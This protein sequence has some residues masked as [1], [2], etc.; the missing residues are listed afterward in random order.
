MS[1]RSSWAQFSPPIDCCLIKAAPPFGSPHTLAFTH[2]FIINPVSMEAD[3]STPTPLC[4]ICTCPGKAIRS[5]T[6]RHIRDE[7][8]IH[9]ATNT[10]VDDFEIPDYQL[11]RCPECS[12]EYAWPM[13]AG[14]AGFYEWVCR[15]P[16][17]YPPNRWEWLEFESYIAAII[18]SG[19]KARILDVGCGSGRF[20]LHY[21]AK[22]G[23]GVECVGIDITPAALSQAEKKD[24]RFILG[25][26]R[27]IAPQ[28]LGAFDLVT[29]FH[30]LEHVEEP[31]Q[32]VEAMTRFAGENGRVAVSTPLSPMSF[33][34]EWPAIMNRPPHHM[35]RWNENAYHA[36]ATR[37]GR[38]AE[39]F[40]E[41][42]VSVWG[43]TS[44]STNRALGKSPDSSSKLGRYAN[45]LLHPVTTLRH[46]RY[47]SARPPLGGRA[48][49]ED[50]LVILKAR[51]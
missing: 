35:T 14:N 33:E 17:Y 9:F 40:S 31:L 28:S 29:S 39:C 8:K 5:D 48:R 49:G 10:G 30:C 7:L 51:R 45:L 46:F 12:L 15:Q 26:H 47:Q 13:V 4:P 18:A 3:S 11:L 42:A 34:F 38:V 43:R 1:F 22:F 32:F 21:K 19:R 6:G 44:N 24:L 27:Q 41:P 2:L 16:G 50:I 36:L 20:L 23:D 37:L 25:D